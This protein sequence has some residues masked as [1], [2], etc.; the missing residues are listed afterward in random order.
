MFLYF[1]VQKFKSQVA[2][3]AAKSMNSNIKITANT[4]RVGPE[5]ENIYNHEFFNS[6]DFICNALD[7]IAA[8]LYIDSKVSKNKTNFFNFNK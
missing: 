5:T 6:L 8:R 7:N 2:S 3:H 4:S 1:L